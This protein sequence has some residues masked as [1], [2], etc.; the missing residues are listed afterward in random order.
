M[1]IVIVLFAVLTVTESSEYFSFREHNFC[2]VICMQFDSSRWVI[3]TIVF[4]RVLR[5]F[6]FEEVGN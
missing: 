6:T 1:V 5:N 3:R 2:V 4:T